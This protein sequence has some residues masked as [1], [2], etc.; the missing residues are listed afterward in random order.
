[1]LL[2]FVGLEVGR[3]IAEDLCSGI[4]SADDSALPYLMPAAAYIRFLARVFDANLNALFYVEAAV[5]T[6]SKPSVRVGEL[7]NS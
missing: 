5:G 3:F 7:K 4:C 1:M 6:L 2:S